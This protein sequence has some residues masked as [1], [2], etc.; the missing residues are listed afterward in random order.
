MS[1]PSLPEGQLQIVETELTD[2]VL[3]NRTTNSPARRKN[4]AQI[5]KIGK[6]QQ[7]LVN[8]QKAQEQVRNIN[9]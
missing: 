6:Y 2:R 9:R 4:E 1:R 3:E 7:K 8:S 5:K